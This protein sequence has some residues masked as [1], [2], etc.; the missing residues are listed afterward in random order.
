[1]S[2]KK[3]ILVCPLNW[4]LGHAT[5]MIPII[6]DA[7]VQGHS[8]IIAS[9]GD[10]LYL[11]QKHFPKLQTIELPNL[12]IQ[13]GKGFFAALI[14]LISIPKILVWIKKDSKKLQEIIKQQKIDLIISDNRWGL[15][16]KAVKSIFVTHQLMVKMPKL[17]SYIEKFGYYLQQHFLKHFDEIW[18]PDTANAIQNI[19]GDLSHKYIPQ[20]PIKYI[21][22]LSQ[23]AKIEPQ[24]EF[25]YDIAVILS[26]PEPHRSILEKTIL[27][28]IESLHVK[29]IVVGGK[30]SDSTQINSENTTYIAFANT[31]E[32]Q[33]IYSQ[34]KH[35]ICRSGYTSLMDLITLGKS[36]IIIPTPSQTEQEY[37]AEYLSKKGWFISLKQDEI[38]EISMETFEKLNQL[39]LI[40]LPINAPKAFSF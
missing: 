15:W 31:A 28:K 19:S 1:M 18:I 6:D 26:G 40:E 25:K 24:L 27:E 34:S 30:L 16:N 35:I 32:L 11:L 39:K 10:A 7:I 2:S 5:R 37:L 9:D 17:F 21:G 4:G 20:K 13:Y 8:V 23:F 3:T 29:A 36:A 12:K 33:E 22:V 38:E 14:F